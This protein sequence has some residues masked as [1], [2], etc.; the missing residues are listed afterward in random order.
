MTLRRTLVGQRQS[1][2]RIPEKVEIV[3]DIRPNTSEITVGG[4]NSSSIQDALG[5]ASTGYTV[6]FPPGRYIMSAAAS[7][8]S[9]NDLTLVGYGAILVETADDLTDHLSFT[10]CDRL[11]ILG[12]SFEAAETHTSFAADSP[13]AERQFIGLTTCDDATVRDIYGTNKRRLLT[14]DT[15]RS[16]NVDGYSFNGFFQEIESGI[17]SNANN[18][19]CVTLKGCDDSTVSNGRVLNHGSACLVQTTAERVAIRGIVG[20]DLHDNGVYISSGKDCTVTN[21][22]FNDVG[23][24]GI[25]TRGDGMTICGNSL[26]DVGND[27]GGGAGVAVEGLS[28]ASDNDN[29]N[30]SGATIIGNT[31]ADSDHG[32]RTGENNSKYLRDVVISGNTIHNCSVTGQVGAINCKINQG[33]TITNNIIRDFDGDYGIF[34]AAQFSDSI[35]DTFVDG[36]VTV[37]TD[38]IT[39]TAHSFNDGNSVVLTTTGTLPAGLS[40]EDVYY[41]SDVDSN[42]IALYTDKELTSIVDITAAAGGG[43]HTITH[44]P[45]SNINVS[46]NSIEQG[47]GSSSSERGGIK[48]NYCADNLVVNGNTFR[49]IDCNIGVRLFNCHQGIVGYNTYL[50][51]QVVRIPSSENNKDITVVGNRGATLNVDGDENTILQNDCTVTGYPASSTTPRTQGQVTI[52]TGEAYMATGTSSSSDWQ[53]ITP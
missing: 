34:V 20:E 51:E 11:K 44:M 14:A 46:H 48:V 4:F 13:S 23:V 17:Q 6:Y 31:I 2:G 33:I 37:G 53:Q 22:T 10:S 49:D 43:T 18:A 26:R 9:I 30:G 42:T 41:V 3:A 16:L 38:Q 28:S 19:P 1:P 39:L 5:S 12:F 8:S 29:A 15:C 40:T 32:I 50:N 36:D 24:D 21:C 27:S 47:S 25:K 35:D 52:D 7:L 45:G